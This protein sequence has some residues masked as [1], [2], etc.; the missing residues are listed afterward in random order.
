M[1][2]TDWLRATRSVIAG[3]ALLPLLEAHYDLQAPITCRLRFVGDNDTYLVRAGET[4]Y[5]LRVYRFGRYWIQGE[6]DYRFEL[7]WL[8]FL[9]ARGLPVSYAI[10]R[11]DGERLGQIAAPEGTRYWAL[12]SFAEGR[13]V[14][15]LD[16][17]QSYLVGQKVA[18]IHLASNDFVTRHQ[19]F[20]SDLEFLLD[21]PV[22]TITQLLGHCREDD[23]AFIT[24]LAQRLK[25]RVLALGVSGDGYGIVGG[26]FNGGNHHFTAAN[27]LTFFDFD[28]CGYGWRAYDLAVFFRNARLREAPP[29]M[30]D[31]F[32][33]GYQ[34]IRTLSPAE[35]RAI[36]LFV[37][38]RQI[39]RLGVRC[40]EVDLSGD[41]WLVD[42]YWDR[43][44]GA[45]RQW[46]KV[47][48]SDPG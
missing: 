9:R 39:W 11:R 7:D 2:P 19:R 42:G 47:E 25:E 35:R 16:R 20:R 5:A 1:E 24:H 15:P 41:E 14:H 45:P 17:Q 38:I 6:A 32:L 29:E 13:V 10:P 8:A 18:E 31:A 37:M 26:D 43:M 12:F 48:S 4:R 27:E 28:L 23:V 34:S 44:V 30:G 36:P 3:D 46:S 40:S 22:A 33:E 21:Q